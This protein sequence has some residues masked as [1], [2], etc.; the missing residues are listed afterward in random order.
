MDETV[1]LKVVWLVS[2]APPAAPLKRSL[3][4]ELSVGSLLEDDLGLLN[5][6][7]DQ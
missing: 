6:R 4:I 7:L 2:Q 3:N 1:R 5:W